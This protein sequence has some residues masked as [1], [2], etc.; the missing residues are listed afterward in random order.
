M[1]YDILNSINK[2][3]RLY[4]PLLKTD[5]ISDR[6]VVLKAVYL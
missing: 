4:E 2:K 1:T 5:V 6:Y 3:D